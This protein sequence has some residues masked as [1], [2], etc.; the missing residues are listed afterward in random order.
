L[1]A[2][3]LSTSTISIHEQKAKVKRNKKSLKIG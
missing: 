2:I 3:H 1:S